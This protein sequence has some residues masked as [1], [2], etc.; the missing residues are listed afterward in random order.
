[1]PDKSLTSAYFDDVYAANADP[2]NFARS[3]YEQK[4]YAATLA[5]LPNPTYKS[6]FEIGCSIWVLSALLAPRCQK[7]LSVDVSETALQQARDRLANCPHVTI[8]QMQLPDESP[9]ELVDLIVLSEV[10]YYWSVADLGRVQQ[11]LLDCLLPNGHLLLVH[12]TPPVHDYPQ[13]GDAVHEQF[14]ALSGPG[15]PLTHRLH[16]RQLT[17]RLDLFSRN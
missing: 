13:T 1:M 2:W 16:Q 14:M 17:Y 6:G 10:A 7:L 15:Q 8:R 5:A 12:W 3:D 9:D 11:Q 4:K